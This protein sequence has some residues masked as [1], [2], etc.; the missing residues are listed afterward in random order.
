MSSG[1]ASKRWATTRGDLAADLAGAPRTEPVA[2]VAARL[3]PVPIAE[4]GVVR[5]S[6]WTTRTDAIGT[7]RVSAATC[8]SVVSWPWPCGRLARVHG[9][10][11]VGLQA[12]GG[13]LGRH[14][15][16]DRGPVVRRP[17]RGL[18][19]R[20]DA[21]AEV[22]AVRARCG[23]LRGNPAWSATRTDLSSA[24][25]SVMPDSVGPVTI[26][27]GISSSREQVAAAHLDRVE[28]ELVGDAVEEAL[29]HPGLGLPRAA[30]RAVRR[31][32]RE[33]DR[34]VELEVTD[35]V[36]AG[37]HDAHDVGEQVELGMVGIR[38]CALVEHDRRANTEDRPVVVDGHLD[39]EDLVARMAGGAQVLDAVLDPL[40][41]LAEEPAR[42]GDR[43]VLGAHERLLAERAADVAVD[44]R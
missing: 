11:A 38:V 26:G 43:D 2:T 18:D 40:D 6:P 16:P 30:V 34:A 41:R 19:E 12:R 21:E 22:A 42:H 15:E 27:H 8:A 35:A 10:R 39:V 17:G 37:E 14:R 29:P 44:A 4:N 1:L 7:P 5:L 28:V 36:R 9:E 13:A 3:P 24:L 23:L 20:G 33:D 32:V 31:L 25:R